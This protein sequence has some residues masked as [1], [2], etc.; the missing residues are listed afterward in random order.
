MKDLNHV[1]YQLMNCLQLTKRQ[2][3]LIGIIYSIIH[4]I[5]IQSIKRREKGKICIHCKWDGKKPIDYLK[6]DIE[7]WQKEL[8][9]ISS[10]YKHD[11]E[12]HAWEAND[13]K[14]HDRY[15][16]TNQCGLVSAAGTDMDNFQQS[17][18][19]IKDYRQLHDILS[20]YTENANVFQLKCTVTTSS[21]V[22]H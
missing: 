20:Q 17:E 16:I 11:M 7:K 12:L 10:I 22:Y 2:L 13:I 19:S 18:W 6:N 3:D 21:I 14:L 1:K 4:K 8:R 9:K 5:I 15:L